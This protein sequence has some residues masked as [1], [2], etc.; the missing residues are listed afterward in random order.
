M[1]AIELEGKPSSKREPGHVRP[2]QPKR[3]DESGKA[4]GVVPKAERLR[5][6]R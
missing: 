4:I 1:S 5:W 3:L 2:L 6:I